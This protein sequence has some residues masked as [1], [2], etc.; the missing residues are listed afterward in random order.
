MFTAVDVGNLSRDLLTDVNARDGILRQK[1]LTKPPQS[2]PCVA[3]SITQQWLSR[4][5][6][7]RTILVI[8]E[9]WHELVGDL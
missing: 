1:V 7:Y 3:G 9:S 2:P 4:K 5:S 6:L 8:A